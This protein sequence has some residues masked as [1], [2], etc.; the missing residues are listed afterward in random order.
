MSSNE[1]HRGSSAPAT[2]TTFHTLEILLIQL[3]DLDLQGRSLPG[4]DDLAHVPAWEP[5]NLHDLEQVS[6]LDLVL[7]YRSCTTSHSGR[8][9][10]P[11]D[12]LEMIYLICSTCG[13]STNENNPST[14]TDKYHIFCLLRL[15]RTMIAERSKRC[16]LSVIDDD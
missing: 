14:R 12:D 11:V 5:Y 10:F 4:L 3:N 1:K 7:L 6:S 2:R 8:S 13:I 16:F 15:L 9:W